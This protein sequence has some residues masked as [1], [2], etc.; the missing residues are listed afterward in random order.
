M[1]EY[2][3]SKSSEPKVELKKSKIVT[4]HKKKEYTT[5]FLVAEKLT[6][7][8]LGIYDTLEEAKKDGEK[9]TYH[10]C[11]ILPF[12]INEKCKY[13]YKPAFENQ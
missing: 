4:V 12:K 9:I 13:L 8:P 11:I 10:N 1:F 2:F 7:S 6:M 5:V 3:Y